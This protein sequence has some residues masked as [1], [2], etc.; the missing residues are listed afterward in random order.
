MRSSSAL[1]RPTRPVM[2]TALA[3]YISNP[4]PASRAKGSKGGTSSYAAKQSPS[5]PPKYARPHPRWPPRAQFIRKAV[6]SFCATEN[7]LV[8][9][10]NISPDM[11][12]VL[13][14]VFPHRQ[15]PMLTAE[16]EAAKRDPAVCFPACGWVTPRIKA[17]VAKARAQA[18]MTWSI[19]RLPGICRAKA[20]Q[21]LP[22]RP[23]RT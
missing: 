20:N 2:A 16:I 7:E 23:P 12:T 14:Q 4:N 22:H 1:A 8:A 17:V 21:R 18:C 15:P 11:V 5:R 9:I 6:D 13:C 10:S 3:E 19:D